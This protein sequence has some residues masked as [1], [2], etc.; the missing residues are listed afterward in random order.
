MTLH[1]NG[2]DWIFGTNGSLTLP[3]KVVASTSTATSGV[4]SIT[5]ASDATL[6]DLTKQIQ[7]LDVGTGTNYMYYL[8]D[9]VEGQIMHF[10][11]KQS[12]EMHYITIFCDHIRY[13]NSASLGGAGNGYGDWLPFFNG[14]FMGNGRTMGT[15]IFIDGAWSFDGGDI[16]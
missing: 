5:T 16:D 4:A 10:V 9:G 12:T 3:G 15:G 2:K 14:S 7:Y 11:A 8:P 1:T 6:L 13:R